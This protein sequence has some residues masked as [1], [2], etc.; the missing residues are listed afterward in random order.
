MYV[1][2]GTLSLARRIL[3][4]SADAV[5]RRRAIA[6]AAYPLEY[7]IDLNEALIVFLLMRIR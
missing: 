2:S 5:K 1:V 3:S 4:R 6:I 7:W